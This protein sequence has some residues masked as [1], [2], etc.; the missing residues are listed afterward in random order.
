MRTLSQTNP[1]LKDKKQ[2]RLANARST[3]SSC[4]VEGIVVGSL[5]INVKL[6]SSKTKAIASTKA[7]RLPITLKKHP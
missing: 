3:K 2:A 4:G 6:D 1:Y 5:K 7:K